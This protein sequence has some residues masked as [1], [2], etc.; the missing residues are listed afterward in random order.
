MTVEEIK[1]TLESLSPFLELSNFLLDFIRFLLWGL[2]KIIVW[3][4]ESISGVYVELFKIFDVL[5]NSEIT[6]I[7]KDYSPVAWTVGG[8][9]IA[10]FG[11]R[12]ML[13]PEMRLSKGV[14]NF[15]FGVLILVCS[16]TI[17][18]LVSDSATNIAT[19]F[20][21]DTKA[22]VVY[23]VVSKNMTDLYK[24]DAANDKQLDSARP[25][26]SK[27]NIQYLN[28][29]EIIDRNKLKNYKEVLAKKLD[30]DEAGDVQ[31]KG[32]SKMF[33]IKETEGYYRYK[34]D[35]IMIALGLIIL[36]AVYVMTSLKVAKLLFEMIYSY[37]LINIFA[38]SD[39]ENGERIKKIIK[40]V[41]N[42][43]LTVVLS[44]YMIYLFGIVYGAINQLD[45]NG[46]TKLIA[47]MGVAL[48]VIDGPVIIQELTGYDAG[49]KSTTLGAFGMLQAG[50]LVGKGLGKVGSATY[51]A[52][53]KG[54][55]KLSDIL[56]G[57]SKQEKNGSDSS[58][59]NQFEQAVNDKMK[60]KEDTPSVVEQGSGTNEPVVTTNPSV[61]KENEKEKA[62]EEQARKN[63]QKYGVSDPNNRKDNEDT[64]SPTRPLVASKES[65]K[66]AKQRRERLNNVQGRYNIKPSME[67]TT[68]EKNT[69]NDSVTLKAPRYKT[70][71]LKYQNKTKD[72]PTRPS[73]KGE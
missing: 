11:I 27:E 44:S 66:Q 60:E 58:K 4:A 42:V 40:N 62:F 36:I 21:G 72:H 16:S 31:V 5:K 64:N 13:N 55:D 51:K 34:Y 8:V 22:T 45:I 59:R 70:T 2:L 30:V 26:I 69:K 39:I 41:L 32:L 65:I 47:Q 9:A 28:I 17:M 6:T 19:N 53:K 33:L 71:H 20:S 15:L 50:V 10:Y 63:Q 49:L 24:V 61:Q 14:R 67:R 25:T 37:T 68:S 38:L 52:G 56:S 43:L 7:V 18:T 3:I 46:F 54:K 35:F 23:E 29:N 1:A 48:A 73:G 12:Y 57:G